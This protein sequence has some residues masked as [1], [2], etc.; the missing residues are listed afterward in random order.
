M[1]NGGGS[2]DSRPLGYMLESLSSALAL[3]EGL[4]AMLRL[5]KSLERG[6]GIREVK[7]IETLK[8]WGGKTGPL[9][10]LPGRKG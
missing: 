2:R 5:L 4:R 3:E 7:F 9:G 1:T 8:P 6:F 10:F